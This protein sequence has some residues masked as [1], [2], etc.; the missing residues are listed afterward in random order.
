MTTEDTQ[1]KLTWCIPTYG[2]YL[3]TKGYYITGVF[4]CK[5][6]DTCRGAHSNEEITIKPEISNWT[7]LDKSNINLLQLMDDI[8]KVIDKSKEYVINQ[9]YRFKINTMHSLRFDELIIFW[10]E[11]ASYHR[12]IIKQLSY[13]KT[14]YKSTSKPSPIDGYHYT[15]D[16]PTFNLEDESYIWAFERTLHLCTTYSTLK[17]EARIYVKDLCNGSVNCKYGAH[18]INHQTCIDNMLTGTCSCIS[19][20][21]FEQK[22]TELKSKLTSF[23]YQLEKIVDNEKY[24]K[25]SVK[26][27]K[28]I[29]T[30]NINIQKITEELNCLSRKVHMTEKGLI[31]LSIR[32]KEKKISEKIIVEDIVVKPT[33]KIIKKQY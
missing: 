33:K 23:R 31:P 15:E 14:S 6:G 11:L 29:D 2:A 13:V 19:K 24:K 21:E 25:V 16:V 8:I 27:K 9:Q 20:D 30:I 3:R 22:Q 26:V 17:K 12:Y 7:T 18:N 32:L 1:I 4:P 28:D 5:F 10:Q